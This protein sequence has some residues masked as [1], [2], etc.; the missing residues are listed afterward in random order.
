MRWGKG[1]LIAVAALL[2]AF[3]VGAA[4]RAP[5]CLPFDV[6]VNLLPAVDAPDLRPAD[7]GKRRVVFLQHGMWRTRYSLGRLERTLRQNGYEVVNTGYPS[8]EDT[9]E[10]HA[11]RLR[12][13][14]ER[15]LGDAPDAEVSFVGHSMGGLVIQEYLRRADARAPHA[16]VYLATPHRGA[17]LADLRRHW[18]LFEIAMGDRAAAQLAT[19]D[20]LHE[21]PIPFGDRS[22]TFV[23][24]I[25]AGNP[26]IPGRDD[27]TVGCDEATF[28]GA[29]A[30][31]T[32]PFGHTRIAVVAAVQRQVLRFLRDR[33]FATE[34]RPG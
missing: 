21:R 5:V 19:T 6:A 22:G 8:T 30:S 10:A 3:C 18:F 28:A 15:H 16:C 1:L 24:D 11:Q 12:D 13:V 14:V 27:G 34:G 9:I 7:D 2:T 25:G 33:A 29:R 26:S 20:P 23:G 32:V 4:L 31:L 17:I